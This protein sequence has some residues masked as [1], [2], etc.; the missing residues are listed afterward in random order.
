MSYWFAS[1]L[2]T[3][4]LNHN[5]L[6]LAQQSLIGKVYPSEKK[7]VDNKEFGYEVIQW[8]Q[9][10][11]NNHL[12]F[13]IESFIDADHFM[14]YSD[15]S[16]RN[17]LFEMDM[18]SGT[19][20]QMTDEQG[21]TQS[22][23]HLPQ[24]HTLWF[25]TKKELKTLNTNT[26]EMR[27]VYVFDKSRPESFAITCDGKYCVFGLNKNPGFS[28]NHSTGP[29]ALFRLDLDSKEVKQIS[30]D[31]GFKISHVQTS[32]TD[33]IMVSYCWQHV[34]DKGAPGMVGNTPNRIW[35][36]NLEGTDGGPVGIQEFGLHRT[37]EFWFPDGKHIGYSARYHFGPNKG[38]QFI[39]MITPDG[40]DNFMMMV[41]VSSSHNQIYSDNRHWVSDL[42]DGLHLVLF[43]IEG[44]EI[45]KKDLLFTHDSSMEGQPS[46]PHPHF[47]PDGKYILFS[48]DRTGKPQVYTVKV[49]IGK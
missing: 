6:L 37:H 17:N 20:T 9:T 27:S 44:K 13:N 42:Y 40:K 12:Y 22:S 36:N 43:T 7:A 35:W 31:L 5:G 1:I 49:D 16:G 23:W 4:V 24:F 32:P 33:P 18:A 19:I 21:L 2:L 46:H 28:E 29:Y 11:S 47:S 45:V 38:N 8:T 41:P 48:T 26:F 3:I 34:Y 15:R 30:P 39:G 25:L 10:G 14:F